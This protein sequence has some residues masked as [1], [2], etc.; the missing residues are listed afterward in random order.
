MLTKALNS[1]LAQTCKSI[2]VIFI[3]DNQKRGVK[4]ANKQFA[5]NI[6]RVDGEYVYTLDDD[7]FLPSKQFVARLRQFA[8]AK[9][10]PAVIMVKGRRPQLKPNILPK[11]SVWGR[12]AK[13]RVTTTNGA[14]F[15]VRQDA[16]KKHVAAYGNRGSGDWNFLSALKSDGGLNFTWFD[17]VAKETQQL[18]RGRKFESCK[19]GW[20]G[21][22]V[23]KFKIEQVSKGDWRLQLWKK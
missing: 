15:V 8:R 4:W 5:A 20:W 14:C 17:F 13:L 12:R 2:E 6:H 7:S 21:R 3:I 18:G 23:K 1:V 16:W 19:P 10:N 22:A 11:P 9:D